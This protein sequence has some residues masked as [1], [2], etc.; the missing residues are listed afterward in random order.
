M[1]ASRVSVLLTIRA[2]PTPR[3]P[4]SLTSST[5]VSSR[6]GVPTTTVSTA[7][8]FIRLRQAGE[9]EGRAEVAGRLLQ[10]GQHGRGR[11]LGVALPDPLQDPLVLL[12][13]VLDGPA[14]G[15]VAAQAAHAA[16]LQRLLHG[17]DQEAE[18]L[19]AGA[20]GQAGV[21]ADVGLVEGHRVAGGVAHGRQGQ[22]HG[23][24]GGAAGL[25]GGQRG[26]VHLQGPAHSS[27]SS[28]RPG[29]RRTAA[30]K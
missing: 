16:G 5:K 18:Q 1:Q 20:G 27:R 30:V 7:T 22:L 13:H 15:Q 6:Q 8:I 24:D 9:G 19:V 29:S 14:A 26:D 3:R 17:L 4:S 10:V 25:G 12:D 11:P 28:S 23:G 2:S 21:E